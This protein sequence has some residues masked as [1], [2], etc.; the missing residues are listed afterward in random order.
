[1]IDKVFVSHPDIYQCT[2]VAYFESDT[3][4]NNHT[5]LSWCWQ[6]ARRV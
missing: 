6:T 2:V 4:S 3:I 5:K 1:M